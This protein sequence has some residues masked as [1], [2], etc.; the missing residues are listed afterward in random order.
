MLDFLHSGDGAGAVEHIN[1]QL[2]SAVVDGNLESLPA[3]YMQRAVWRLHLGL[4]VNAEGDL[5]AAQRCAL[6]DEARTEVQLLLVQCYRMLDRTED[7]SKALEALR[8]SVQ[9]GSVS[10]PV[11][12]Q[13][14]L[15]CLHSKQPSTNGKVH[16]NNA[17]T[18]SRSTDREGS[19]PQQ[20]RK[21]GSMMSGFL[22]SSS[23]STASKAAK[24]GC[25][26]AAE[27]TSTPA[28]VAA[29]AP[30][31]VASSSVET[32]SRSAVP[33]E[34]SAR[35]KATK[36]TVYGKTTIEEEIDDVEG[37]DEEILAKGTWD[38]PQSDSPDRDISQLDD[39]LSR[40]PKYLT[41][42]THEEQSKL[43]EVMGA[44]GARLFSLSEQR[45]LCVDVRLAPGKGF[46]LSAYLKPMSVVILHDGKLSSA[47]RDYD[48]PCTPHVPHT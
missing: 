17:S 13:Q 44:A 26:G 7:E 25:A 8:A 18:T 43:A 39:V 33:K 1:D 24:N 15:A 30:Q 34:S 46:P 12:M 9:A 36:T 38:E 47:G 14:L 42:M 19:K 16:T 4:P 45:Q 11:L 10:S 21:K 23:A 28:P 41:S 29:A 37:D 31:P 22:S 27:P 6:P 3:L 5:L 32:S 35:R 40:E 48:C 2:K 20:E